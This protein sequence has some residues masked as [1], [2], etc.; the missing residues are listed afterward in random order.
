MARKHKGNIKWFW[1]GWNR[2]KIIHHGNEI[3]ALMPENPLDILLPEVLDDFTNN[4]DHFFRVS[5]G[6]NTLLD[7]TPQSPTYFFHG[8]G[9]DIVPYENA[10]VTYDT[11]V[12][13]GAPN[14]SL[15]LFSEEL[16][17]HAEVAPTCLS[18][19]YNV[20]LDYQAISPKGDLN[21]DGLITIEDV[22]DLMESI[23][24]END[25]TEFQWWAGDCDYDDQ[26]SVMDLLMVADLIE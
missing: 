4:E 26:H 2:E 10:Q 12:A 24:I 13:N 8:M 17:G 23:L 20:I 19:G 18:A 11:F 21:S 16:G 7:W 3:D 1:I 15:T 22:N 9:D 14:I 25:L 5:L 6:E